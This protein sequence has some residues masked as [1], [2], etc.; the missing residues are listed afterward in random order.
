MVAYL[1][2]ALVWAA[3]A[4]H[5]LGERRAAVLTGRP[6]DISARSRA[7]MFYGGLLTIFVALSSPVE[8]LAQ[9]LLWA[10]M[11]EHLL[12][13]LV[14]APLIVLSAP[15]MS[16]WRPLPLGFRRTVAHTLVRSPWCAPLRA[17]GAAVTRPLGAWLLFTVNL[18]FWHLPALYDLTLRNTT[19]HALE[20]V[21]F[22]VFGVLFW[23]QVIPSPPFKP[24]LSHLQRVVYLV[25]A[26]IPN[27]GVAMYLAFSNSALYAPYAELAHRPGN[28][29][30]LADQQIAAGI[31]WSFG[32]LPFAIAIALLVHRWLAGQEA[33]ASVV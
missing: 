13:L 9:R 7:L 25:A 17:I 6:R 31:M 8:N 19:V 15:W 21:T 29:S 1:P 33:R 12:L 20:H 26:T 4:L 16:L 5:L 11:L 28:I 14:A 24:T 22:L 3:L 2:L 27:V 32:D 10:H 30:A 23:L 18:V